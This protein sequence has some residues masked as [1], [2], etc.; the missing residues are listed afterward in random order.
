[1]FDIYSPDPLRRKVEAQSAGKRTILYSAKGQP[2]YMYVVPRFRLN[3]VSDDLGDMLHP[4]FIVKNSIKDAFFYACYPASLHQSELL[5][6]PNQKPATLLDLSSFQQYAQHT[7]N[8]FHLSTNAEWAALMLWCRHHNM[9]E[10]GNTDYGRS[11]LHPEQ[12]VD[13]V[14]GKEAGDTDFTTGDPTTITGPQWENWYH[15]NSE[16]GISD[17]CGNLWEWQSGMQLNAG[18]IQII[19]DN[20]AVFCGDP[21]ITEQWH[22]IALATGKL[23]PI[24]HAKSAK[25]DA[26]TANNDGNAGTPILST[27]IKHYNG[28]PTDNGYPAG[29]MDGDFNAI[30]VDENSQVPMLFKALGLYPAINQHDNNQVYLRNYGERALM[31]GGAWYSQHVAGM[32]TLCLSHHQHHRSTS[33]GGRLAWIDLTS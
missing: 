33:V 11:F 28:T 17:L 32:R 7:G 9:I 13:R 12:C 1:M 19:K 16:F 6:L 10:D 5:S 4:A 24:N 22:A 26:P 31:R 25:Y 14:D 18:E 27:S 15:D 3:E 8:G 23:L 21:S 20:D 30:T 29:L 2:N